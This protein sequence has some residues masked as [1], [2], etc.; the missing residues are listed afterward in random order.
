MQIRKNILDH[1]KTQADIAIE[2]NN[3]K[4]IGVKILSDVDDTLY[5]SGGKFPAGCDKEYPKHQLYP[6]C[7]S[8]FRSLD[9]QGQVDD[10]A[11]NLVFL[12]ARPHAY[13]DVAEEHSYRL[14]KKLVAE[15]KMHSI[16]TLLPGQIKQGFQAMTQY[17]FYKTLAWKS[18][19]E[20]K[21]LTFEN[22]SAMY[23]EYKYVFCGDD[24]QGDL[25]AGELMAE[26]HPEKL[27]GV[28]IHR[29]VDRGAALNTHKLKEKGWSILGEDL[30]EPDPN[31]KTWDHQVRQ[32]P[33][34]KRSEVKGSEACRAAEDAK[35]GG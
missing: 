23:P 6:G 18:V 34:A 16:P 22:Y 35:T 8:F 26:R 21:F 24:G 32:R 3:D 28:F 5:S 19:G 31:M 33:W 14:F 10:T 1:F 13:K 9:K 4:P 20:L 25:L 7:L 30:G 2:R 12:S 15:E 29:V 17:P 27:L 11:C